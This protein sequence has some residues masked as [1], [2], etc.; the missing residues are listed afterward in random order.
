MASFL[1]RVRT[2][3]QSKANMTSVE[4]AQQHLWRDCNRGARASAQEPKSKCSNEVC[5][6]HI[7]KE[8]ELMEVVETPELNNKNRQAERKHEDARGCA[9]GN[10]KDF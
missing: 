4:V 6:A 7:E 2:Q 1:H 8:V 3:H 9:H 10:V 5:V